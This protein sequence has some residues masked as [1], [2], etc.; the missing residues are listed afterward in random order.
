VS[1][2]CTVLIAAPALLP[3]LKERTAAISL[4]ASLLLAAVKLVVGLMIGS[5][6]LRMVESLPV[7]VNHTL[8]CPRGR[9]ELNLRPV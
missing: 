8:R 3:A 7:G 5:L 2:P 9:V 6:A 1:Q 4:V